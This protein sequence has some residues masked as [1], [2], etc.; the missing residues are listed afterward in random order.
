MLTQTTQSKQLAFEIYDKM[1]I[2]TVYNLKTNIYL[3]KA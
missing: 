2:H 1:H 3:K